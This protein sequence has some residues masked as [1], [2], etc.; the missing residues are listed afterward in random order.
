[1]AIDLLNETEATVDEAQLVRLVA[2]DLEKLFVHPD[3]DVSLVLV[4]VA[5]MEQ[6][7]VQWMDEPGPTDV[8]SF[9]MDELRP[10]SHDRPTPAGLL[11]DIVLCPEV[12]Q[13]QAAEAGHSLMAE[14][15]LLT[16]HGLLHLLGF[17]HA[18]PA[19][20]DEMFTLQD[21]L[22]AGFEEHDRATPGRM[23]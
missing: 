20:R 18:E 5:A 1:M 23:P 16:T 10:G 17:D 4:D 9:P 12:A 22:L 2:F 15:R 7:H 21:R 3:A 14:L 8:L 19:D 13:A 6:L 11:G